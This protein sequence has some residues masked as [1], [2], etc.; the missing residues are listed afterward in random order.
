MFNKNVSVSLIM[1]PVIINVNGPVFIYF[2][3]SMEHFPKEWGALSM[4]LHGM[5]INAMP[6]WKN[7]SSITGR[8]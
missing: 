1:V 8:Y 6:T 4:M 7:F 5:S 2:L 3:A